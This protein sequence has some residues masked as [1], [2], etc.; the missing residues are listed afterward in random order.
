MD[1]VFDVKLF[2]QKF[3]FFVKYIPT[4]EGHRPLT[5]CQGALPLDPLGAW[6]QTPIRLAFP[7][8][9]SQYRHFYTLTIGTEEGIDGQ[10]L[11]HFRAIRAHKTRQFN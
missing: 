7:R 3:I 5:A 1:F 4:S 8:S 10:K 11:G 6:P 2:V 9:S